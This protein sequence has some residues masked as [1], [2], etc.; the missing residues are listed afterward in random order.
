MSI[1]LKFRFSNKNYST[2]N[3]FTEVPIFQ[4]IGTNV[5]DEIVP[6]DELVCTRILEILIP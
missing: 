6:W 1:L 2:K 4:K 3:Y 5:F